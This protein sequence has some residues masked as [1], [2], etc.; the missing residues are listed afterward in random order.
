[1]INIIVAI[2]KNYIIWNKGQL[3]WHIPEDLKWFKNNTINKTILMW[4]NTYISIGKALPNRKNIILTSKNNINIDQAD[5]CNNYTEII[6]KYKYSKEDIFI[7]WWSQI[8]NLFLKHTNKIY[9]TLLNKKYIWDTKFP[10]FKRFYKI[11][12]QKK[13]KEGR[14]C[15]YKNK[16]IHTYK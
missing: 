10:K 15:I 16:K 11:I 2:W 4:Y 7:I 8:Y 3:P 13:F 14:F 1:M 5:I 6:Q 9:I 12:E